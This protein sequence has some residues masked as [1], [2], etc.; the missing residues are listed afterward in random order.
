[1]LVHGHRSL[2][3]QYYQLPYTAGRILLLTSMTMM[4]VSY[5]LTVAADSHE[6]QLL[7]QQPE[8]RE[9]RLPW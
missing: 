3:Y 7:A 8:L 1:M 2:K 6:H 5:P 9:R 4:C